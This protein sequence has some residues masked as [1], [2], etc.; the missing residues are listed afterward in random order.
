MIELAQHIEI[1]L[2]EHDCVI[3]PGLGG[4]VAHYTPA[5]RVQEENL[6]L[7]PIRTIGFNPGLLLNDGL[8]VQSY[9][10]VHDTDFSDATR[11]ME[12]GVE[13][14]MQSLRQE[15]KVELP[16]I[17][18]LHYSI[19]HTYEFHPY[20]NRLAT[21]SLYGLG[22]FELCEL[23]ATTVP[24]A[25]KAAV[26]PMS[27]RHERT[28]RNIRFYRSRL[29]NVAAIIAIVLT[30][31]LLSIPVGNT[32]V[33]TVS[34]AGLSPESLMKDFEK[35]SLAHT[36]ICPTP[37]QE[38]PEATVEKE[39]GKEEKQPASQE[40]RPIVVKEVKVKQTGTATIPVTTHA[41]AKPA[42]APKSYHLIVASVGTEKDARA[43][44]LQLSGQGH[45]DAQAIIGDG[46]M[47]VSI[48]SY[49]NAT[50]AYTAL[51]KLRQQEAYKNAWVLKKKI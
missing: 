24:P 6:F 46:K 48:A 12:L 18:S 28:Q 4:F 7:P 29:A 33:G 25:R 20:D 11:M 9:M 10:T 38:L 47:R 19:H 44:A 27:P 30:S 39:A 23:T 8:L 45:D 40:K 36:L 34:Q 13:E 17:G 26:V 42:S 50:E 35:Q 22:S 1:L 31:F 15:G 14:L 21:P 51:N 16:H 5:R 32:T 49:S 3:V 37:S 41:D 2:L 43:M